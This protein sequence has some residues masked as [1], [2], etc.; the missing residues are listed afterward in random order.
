[1]STAIQS[2]ATL[3]YSP[4]VL[5]PLVEAFYATAEVQPRNCLLAYLVLP[6]TLH[7][8]SRAFLKASRKTSSLRTMLNSAD[9]SWLYGL[10]QRVGEYHSL[11]DRCLQLAFDS[12]GIA[13]QDDLSVIVRSRRLSTSRYMDEADKAAAGLG[14]I[15]RPLDVAAVYRSL[16]IKTL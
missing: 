8:V 1:M 7:P 4:F 10:P 11:T 16:G 14:R 3:H 6:L 13:L 15:L 9:E 5:A 2:L 12:G